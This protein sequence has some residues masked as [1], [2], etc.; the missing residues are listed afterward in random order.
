MKAMLILAIVGFNYFVGIFYGIV[1]CFTLFCIR[2]SISVPFHI[3]KTKAPL[4]EN[5]SSTVTSPV[6]VLILRSTRERSCSERSIDLDLNTR[7]ETIV[8]NDGSTDNTLDL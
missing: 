4:R 1:T 2:A 3:R 6:S 8:I 5:A 7:L